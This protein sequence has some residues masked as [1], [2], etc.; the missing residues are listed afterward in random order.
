MLRWLCNLDGIDGPPD[1]DDDL[2]PEAWHERCTGRLDYGIDGT[3]D[4]PG[5][6]GGR[7]DGGSPEQEDEYR[8]SGYRI[9]HFLRDLCL[10]TVKWRIHCA[11]VYCFHLPE[12]G[13][14]ILQ[15]SDCGYF[16]YERPG[17]ELFPALSAE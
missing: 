1:A 11:D 6:S 17:A 13:E 16:A 12:Y 14:T 9:G 8:V 10:D 7:P 4:P 15:F 2:E 5:E 3:H